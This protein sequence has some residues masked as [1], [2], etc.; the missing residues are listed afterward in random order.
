MNLL[1][2]KK[3]RQI[4]RFRYSHVTSEP[5][6]ARTFN[7]ALSLISPPEYSY[8]SPEPPPRNP[9]RA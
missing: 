8:K 5:L 9:I 4:D 2:R 3:T 1:L 6:K 7:R